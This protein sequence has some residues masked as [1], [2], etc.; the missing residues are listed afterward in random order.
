MNI[1]KLLTLTTAIT[2][3]MTFAGCGESYEGFQKA[4]SGLHYCFHTTNTTAT[5]PQNG[6][7]LTIQMI[8]KL[9]N[10]SVIEP[11]KTFAV[12][13][14]AP[15]F[16]GD[17]YDAL[18]MMHQTDS[19]T[20][21]I[22]AN[23]YF[24]YY[25]GFVPPFVKDDKTMLWI[26]LKID[27]ILSNTA[28]QAKQITERKSVE[29]KTITA[30][31]EEHHYKDIQPTPSGL[32]YIEIQEGKGKTPVAGQ[33]CMMNYTGKFLHGEVFDSNIGQS[34]FPF[35]LGMG[36]VIKGWDEGVALMKKGGKAIL[37]IPSD[38]AY[39]QNGAG[40]IPPYTPLV[41]EVELV[42]IN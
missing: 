38:L 11:T 19:A 24:S 26:S 23:K 41:F 37:I 5:K 27:S 3:V 17:V 39:G 13:M 21:I 8:V 29:A 10:D 6:D 20:F 4:D 33:T 42:D 40:S 16:Q 12:M 14:Q 31:L 1:K 35:Q 22:N 18:N 2:V 28:Y 9:E 36:K 32:Y 30:Y 15:K 7:V 34:V 25:K